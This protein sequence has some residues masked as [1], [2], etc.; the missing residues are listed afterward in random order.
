MRAQSHVVGVALMLGLGV[1]ALGTL[2]LTIGAL[3][4]SQAGSAD[5]Q[6]VAD[7]FDRAIQGAER[8]GVHRHEI[9]FSEG[10]LSTADRTLRILE[11]G[12]VIE[13]VPVDALV[14]END[15]HRV[16]S[17]VG[18]VVRESEGA[19]FVSEPRIVGSE[20]NAVLVVSA[21]ALN[22]SGVTAGGQGGVTKTIRTN[23]SHERIE[24]GVGEYAVAVETTTPRPFE[25]YFAAHNATV[26]RRQFADDEAESVVARYP[27]RRE[28]YLVVHD[29]RLEVN[30][31]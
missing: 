14:F 23:V 8:T 4:D 25:E 11:N 17:L 24:L 1:I 28:A 27:G 7:G 5:A 2:T 29:L 31:G 18:A 20:E 21:P 13:R 19:W 9:S 22:A 12:S 15:D 3:V 16:A 30:H 26:D 10:H 6:R